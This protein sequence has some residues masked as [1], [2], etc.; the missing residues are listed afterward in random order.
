MEICLFGGAFDPIH[1]GHTSI[2]SE[3]LARQVCN[4]IIVIPAGQS[5]FKNEHFASSFHRM[6]MLEIAVKNIPEVE[7]CE[8][9]I[10]KTGPSRTVDTIRH[11]C[12]ICTEDSLKLVIGQ[13]NLSEFELWKNYEQILAMVSLVVLSRG[14][15]SIVLPEYLTGCT[16]TLNDFDFPVS[17]TEVRQKI[18][19]SA[20]L[21]NSVDPDVLSYIC[22]EGL[23]HNL[24]EG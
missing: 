17:S 24:T 21:D 20:D 4:K 19:T 10:N 14:G 1:K 16:E 6:K 7:I 5:P 12:S 3:L 11:L 8:F 2:M 13:D 15:S 18:A 9:E 22:A 23:Y